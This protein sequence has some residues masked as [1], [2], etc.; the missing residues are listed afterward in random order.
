MS[1]NSIYLYILL[2]FGLQSQS[3]A[4]WH[5]YNQTFHRNHHS[6]HNSSS[7]CQSLKDATRPLSNSTILEM[8]LW[9]GLMK[10]FD[11]EN[12]ESLYGL[13]AGLDAIWK[14]QFPAN[15]SNAKFLV[16]GGWPYGFGSRIHVE[17]WGLA[18]AMELGRIYLPHPDGDNV[19]W[20]THNDHCRKRNLNNLECYY[21]KWSSC[22]IK[23]ALDS[24]HNSVNDFKITHPSDFN[25]IFDNP[26]YR[27]KIISTFEGQKGL[28][29]IY[30]T[31]GGPYVAKKFIPS[32]VRPIIECS[33]MQVSLDYYWWRAV[34]ATFLLRPNE[35]TLDLMAVHRDKLQLDDQ[36]QCIAMFVRHGD[37]GIEMKLIDFR[38]YAETAKLLWDQGY[39]PRHARTV[40]GPS[41]I[42]GLNASHSSKFPY[43]PS[44][45]AAN[46]Q[47]TCTIFVTTEDPH[48]I[49]EAEQWSKNNSC[50]VMFTTLYDRSTSIMQYDWD[51]QHKKNAP[52][53]HHDLEYISM[54]LNLEYALRCEAWVCTIASNSCRVMDELRATLGAKANR[55]FVDLSSETCV[56]P[57][58]I[59]TEDDVIYSFGE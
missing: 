7:A 26:E 54:L 4:N 46:E 10:A 55:Y 51:T 14:N 50:R 47:K 36:E 42:N 57:P 41:K 1:M 37:K 11:R 9:P 13:Q 59:G 32:A 28:N 25:R 58:C 18:I 17:G 30:T 56:A 44:N 45:A 52:A 33:P 23:D 24:H 35:A 12:G 15:C 40:D 53:G 31:G 5:A 21:E 22:T 39:L 6:R 8:K 29:I 19:F 27:H 20:E 16:S 2:V 3:K 43:S 34:S 38:T 49:A 48:V